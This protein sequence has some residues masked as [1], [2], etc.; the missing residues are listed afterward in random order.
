MS[1]ERRNDGI[2]KRPS[3]GWAKHERERKASERREGV[4]SQQEKAKQ[5]AVPSWEEMSQIFELR[6]YN[7]EVQYVRYFKHRGILRE[8]Y[9]GVYKMAT[10]QGT[11]DRNK[12]M[13]RYTSPSSKDYNP[14]LIDELSGH[15]SLIRDTLIKPGRRRR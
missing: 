14:R 1:P 6:M 7:D 8:F 11:D 10:G 3:R 13:E 4:I 9:D 15:L 12:F 2:R 5:F